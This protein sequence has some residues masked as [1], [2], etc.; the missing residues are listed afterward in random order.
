[1]LIFFLYLFSFIFSPSLLPF[2]FFFFLMLR[3]PPRSTLTD[4]LFPSTTLFRSQR[5][6]ARTLGGDSCALGRVACAG[7]HPPSACRNPLGQGA[8]DEPES[9]DEQLQPL[10]RRQVGR[11][12]GRG[13][14]SLGDR[15][16]TRLN[17]SH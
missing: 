9:E 8:C 7:E 16:S 1:M 3:R 11:P 13:G 2:C 4:T 10:F 17:S 14:R 15:K 12:G 6:H 5:D